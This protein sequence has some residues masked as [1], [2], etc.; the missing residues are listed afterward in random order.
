MLFNN[1]M[2]EFE[3]FMKGNGVGLDMA[4]MLLSCLLFA[5]DILLFADSAE[6]LQNASDCLEVLCKKN[7]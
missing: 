3:N 5:D 7:N 6:K 4:G 1:F 2:N